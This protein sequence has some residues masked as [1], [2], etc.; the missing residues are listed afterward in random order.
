MVRIILFTYTLLMAVRMQSTAETTPAQ[1]W[2]KVLPSVC[3]FAAT[4]GDTV[5]TVTDRI[6]QL[7]SS[8]A[9]ISQTQPIGDLQNLI[10]GQY[11]FGYLTDNTILLLKNRYTMTKISLSGEVLWSKS[12]RDT[13]PVAVCNDFTEN[14]EGIL[15]FCGDNNYQSAIIG[16]ISPNGELLFCK[17]D[18]SHGSFNAIT[19][20]GRTIYLSAS[21]PSIYQP[22]LIV[23][24]D[25]DGN[26]IKTVSDNCN[27]T[28]LLFKDDHIF[29]LGV[30]DGGSL[31]KAKFSATRDILLK[32]F[33]LNGTLSDSVLFD[34]GKY[35][36]PMEFVELSDGFVMITVSDETI[37]MGTNCL[38]YFITK[39]SSDL[40]QEWQL[41]FG[42]DSSG[43]TGDEHY[44]T[45]FADETETILASHNDTLIRYAV[46]FSEIR[47]H[48]LS[49][50][51]TRTGGLRVYDLKGCLLPFGGESLRPAH[52]SAILLAKNGTAAKQKTII[53]VKK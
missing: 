48:L 33:D 37:N 49:G 27:G 52:A 4:K 45:F 10:K 53:S 18:T 19:L 34:Y 1:S 51:V 12:L 47:R 7:S 16:A 11:S 43:L 21:A 41:R 24:F 28:V 2:S 13:L 9:I 6:T 42:T 46:P 22:S 30:L 23:S 32:K 8:G 44:R 15:Y 50:P 17:E 25:T 26:F 40:Q 35:E 20:Y 31:F 3:F 38:N 29:S 36:T 5:I 39:I 14:N